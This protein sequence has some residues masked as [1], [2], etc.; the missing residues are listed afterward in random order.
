MAVEPNAQGTFRAINRQ[1][2]PVRVG[3]GQ[4]EKIRGAD[5]CYK[6][7]DGVL[8]DAGVPLPFPVD[9][10]VS[11]IVHTAIAKNAYLISGTGKE[12]DPA[13]YFDFK[14]G[15]ALLIVRGERGQWR[16]ERSA[17]RNHKETRD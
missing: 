16:A 17:K 2:G 8:G 5:A 7:F 1:T 15:E 12:A 14:R 4:I 6:L 10:V 11:N 9:F 13:I 3:V